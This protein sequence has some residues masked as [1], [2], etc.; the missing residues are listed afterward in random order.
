MDYTGHIRFIRLFM[1]VSPD[2]APDVIDSTP[3]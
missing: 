2:A 1:D 3:Q